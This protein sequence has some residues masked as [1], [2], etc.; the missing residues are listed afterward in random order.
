MFF[1]FHYSSDIENHVL[2]ALTPSVK[3]TTTLAQLKEKLTMSAYLVYISD[4]G[5]SK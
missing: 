4:I 1:I 2:L 5:E 3:N